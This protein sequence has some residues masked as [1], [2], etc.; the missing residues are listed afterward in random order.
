MQPIPRAVR[1]LRPW[2]LPSALLMLAAPSCAPTRPDPGAEPAIA[3]AAG[4]KEPIEFRTQ[5]APLDEPA[6]GDTLTLADAIRRAATTDTG[7]QAALARVRI[8]MADADQARLLPNPLLNFVLRWGTSS[9]QIEVSLSEDLLA[10]LTQKRRSSAADN[11]LR[12]SAADAVT[13]ALDVVASVQDRYAAVQCLESLLPLL[14]ERRDLMDRLIAT[15]QSRLDAQEGTRGDLT[16]LQAQ[17]VELDADIADSQALLA[18]DRLLLARMIGEPSSPA[19]WRIDPW[20]PPPHVLSSQAQWLSAALTNR[21]EIQ[22]AL[23]SLAAL[24]DSAD[25]AALAA[26]DGLGAGVD[27]QKDGDWSVGPS[28]SVPIPILDVGSAR[29]ARAS[30]EQIE[31]LHKLTDARRTVVQEVRVALLALKSSQENVTRVQSQL[32]PLEEHRRE[33]AEQLYRAGQHDITALFLAEQD[34]RAARARSI[35]LQLRASQALIRLQRAVGGPGIAESVIESPVES[36]S[37]SSTDSTPTSKPPSKPA[38]TPTSPSDS[39]P[40]AR[41]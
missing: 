12:Q 27:A 11:L 36:G 18:Q 4:L 34:L 26:W 16:A 6:Q 29:T 19:D 41:P 15:A 23:W 39:T 24:S 17:R 8:A 20:S 22:S 13:V 35:Q 1:A 14:Q 28:L 33:Q 5:G 38:S 9:P 3:A 21:P 30:A 31:A 2:I 32:L 10:L 7:I 25:A 37:A 40:G